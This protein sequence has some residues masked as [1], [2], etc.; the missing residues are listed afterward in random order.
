MLYDAQNRILFSGGVFGGITFTLSLFATPQ[1]WEGIRIW[2]QM[3]IPSQAILQRAIKVVRELDPPPLMIAPQHGA[4]LKEDVIPLVLDKLSTVPV[5]IEVPRTTAID[6]AMYIEAINDV[7]E[8]I[9]RHAGRDIIE[10]LFHRLDEDRSF[11]HLFTFK[12]G[13]L[14]DIK[15]DILGDVMGAFKMFLYALIED[16]PASIQ[17]IVREAV[18]QSNW[19]LPIFMQTFVRRK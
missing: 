11:P 16:Q 8:T 14:T 1:H 17:E 7:L 10:N 3:Y 5:G 9:T 19:D 2:H 13:H 12:Q 4:I 18:L 15:D 6:K